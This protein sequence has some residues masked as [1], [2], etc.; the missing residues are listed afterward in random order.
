MRPTLVIFVK[1]PLPGRVKTRLAR[2]VGAVPAA[3]WFRHQSSGLVRRMA[4]DPRWRTVLAVSP[5]RAGIES[6]IWPAGIPRWP[7]GSGDLGRRMARAFDAML[8]G[9]VIIIG[10][11]I[12]GITPGLIA[13]AFHHL[14]GADAVIGPATDGGYWLI[15]LRRLG[16]HSPLD[17][18][19]RV[20]WSGPHAM[21]DTL[22]RLAPRRVMMMETLADVDCLD[23]L[24]R[25]GLP[26]P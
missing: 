10:A 1:E 13:R 26:R 14:R 22:A 20:R 8:P 16:P 7:Q 11:D 25:L 4:R 9:P 23:D 15:G 6:R 21:S 12:P 2:D 18:L 17:L 24:L 19:D 5:D 3:W